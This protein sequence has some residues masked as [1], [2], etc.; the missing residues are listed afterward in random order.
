MVDNSVG[1]TLHSSIW[2]ISSPENPA[3][4]GCPQEIDLVEQY[5]AVPGSAVSF[6]DANVHPFNGTKSSH[7]GECV[8]LAYPRPSHSTAV[9]DWTTGWTT[10]AVD[11]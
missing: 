8:K 7:D 10:F 3:R 4:S 2:L 5:A 1:F 6:A 11:W 9:G